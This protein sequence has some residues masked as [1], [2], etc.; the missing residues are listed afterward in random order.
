[1]SKNSEKGR[2]GELAVT[3]ILSNIGVHEPGI[4]VIRA[5]TTTTPEN[6]VDIALKCPH[7]FSKKLD[8]I[9]AS[10]KSETALA[11]SQINVRVQVKNYSKPISKA[12]AQ[13]FVD[14]ISR[15]QD[16][17]EHWGVGGTRLTRGAQEVLAKANEVAPV[18]WYTASDFA[19]IQAQY[20]AIPFTDI[21]CDD[22]ENK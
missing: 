2:K 9:V 16:F 7:N 3:G 4:E 15:N 18:K 14:D 11:N 21:N 5:N 20:P 1:M 13:G 6:G 17:A 12:V 8:E 22:G 19:K 10:G